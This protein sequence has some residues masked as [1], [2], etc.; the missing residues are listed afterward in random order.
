MG[1]IYPVSTPFIFITIYST[2]RSVN[3]DVSKLCEF[4]LPFMVV[5]SLCSLTATSGVCGYKIK[6]AIANSAIDVS[7][8]SQCTE[9]IC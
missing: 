6:E 8:F 3:Q 9:V 5:L 7:R 2:I 4:A 1:V